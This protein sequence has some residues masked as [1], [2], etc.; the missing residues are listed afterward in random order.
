MN[1]LFPR[2]GRNLTV[3]VF[4]ETAKVFEV[5][6]DKDCDSYLGCADTLPE[7]KRIALEWIEELN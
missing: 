1:R 7:A 5:F 2:D 3:A 6:A 4:D